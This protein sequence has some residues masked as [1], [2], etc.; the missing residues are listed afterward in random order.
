MTIWN[1]GEA[2]GCWKSNL[3]NV[4]L[5]VPS[6]REVGVWSLEESV[7]RRWYVKDCKMMKL[8]W[9]SCKMKRKRTKNIIQWAVFIWALIRDKCKSLNASGFE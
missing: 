9:E 8:P 6:I 3:E 1:T 2:A 5:G 4:E 7:F